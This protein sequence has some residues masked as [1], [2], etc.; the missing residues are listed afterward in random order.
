MKWKTPKENCADKLIHGTSNGGASNGN[1]KLTAE[2][3]AQ[4]R[5]LRGTDTAAVIGKKF[6]ISGPAVSRIQ[7]GV[8]W[9]SVGMC[10]VMLAAGAPKIGHAHE[11]IPTAAKPQGWN[12]PYSCCSGIDCREVP[13]A[14]II[15]GS[16]GYEIRKTGEIILMSDPKIKQ[17]PDGV[18]HWC[19]VK[20]RDDGKTICLFVPPRGF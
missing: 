5:E 9:A 16:R 2:Q 20:G 18:F 15:E 14:D 19:S 3:V 8:R 4:I 17:S 13:D 7:T 1:A 12:Y 6:G 11:A 10:A